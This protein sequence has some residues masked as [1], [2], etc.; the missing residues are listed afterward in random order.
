MTSETNINTNPVFSEI[1]SLIIDKTGRIIALNSELKKLISKAVP[2][3]N[4]FELFD[5]QKIQVFQKIFADARKYETA[6]RDK[7]PLEKDSVVT[8]Y[9]VEISPL[10]S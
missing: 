2:Q 3:S 1:P 10:R 6:V 4:F 7:I 5:E 9:E 8:D